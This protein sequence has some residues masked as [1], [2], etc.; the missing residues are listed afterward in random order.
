MK[1][2][3]WD[4]LLNYLTMCIIV[5][6]DHNFSQNSAIRYVLVLY[7]S[8][9]KEEAVGFTA[10]RKTSEVSKVKPNLETSIASAI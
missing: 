5:K 4:N 10:I 6:Q 2:S 1:F 3:T 9:Q 7:F 8:P